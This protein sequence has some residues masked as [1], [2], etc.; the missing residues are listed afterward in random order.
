MLRQ[1]EMDPFAMR[2]RLGDEASRRLAAIMAVDVVGSSRLVEA[3]EARALT[4][5]K[6]VLDK[7]LAPAAKRYGGRVVKLLGDGA[8]LEFASPVLAVRCAVEVQ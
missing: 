5:I 7:V 4:G 2:K 1:A 8:L 6:A 3:D